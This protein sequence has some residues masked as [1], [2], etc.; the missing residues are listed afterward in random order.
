MQSDP[1]LQLFLE[2]NALLKGHFVLTSNKHSD[3]YFEKIKLI[4][5]PYYLEKIVSFL[6][7]KIEASSLDFDYIV[8]PAYGAIAIGFLTAL[9]TYKLFAFSQRENE[10]MAIRSGFSDISGKKAIIVED[11]VTT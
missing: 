1:I 9:K 10:K 3:T 8:S 7:E 6:V 2:C 5:N 4:E 11:I